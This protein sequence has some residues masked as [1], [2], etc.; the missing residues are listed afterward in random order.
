MP[1]KQKLEA[2]PNFGAKTIGKK[3]KLTSLN[4][5]ASH[6]RVNRSSSWTL[7][8]GRIA[9]SAV[10]RALLLSAIAAAG[11]FMVATQKNLWAKLVVAA[12][13]MLQFNL[14]GK[15][16]HNYIETRMP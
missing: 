8:A 10:A 5:K 16:A 6:S 9:S 12:I 3:H 13:A 11:R 2:K 1:Q 14:E 15:H 4:P 7:G